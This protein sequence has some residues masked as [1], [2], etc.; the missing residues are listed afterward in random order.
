MKHNGVEYRILKDGTGNRF[1]VEVNDD[2]FMGIKAWDV[3]YEALDSLHRVHYV[4]GKK[5]PFKL[6]RL[7]FP[8]VAIFNSCKEA[9]VAAIDYIERQ[10]PHWTECKC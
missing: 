2:Y 3:L 5:C 10:N 9:K 6:M 1:K 4:T 8:V 7:T